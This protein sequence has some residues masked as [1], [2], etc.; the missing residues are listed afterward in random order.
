MNKNEECIIS[1]FR[2]FTFFLGILLLIWTALSPWFWDWFYMMGREWISN[3]E[4]VGIIGSLCGFTTLIIA[5][6]C[7]FVAFRDN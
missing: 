7:F 3:R 6:F 4:V 1:L 5:V 2:L